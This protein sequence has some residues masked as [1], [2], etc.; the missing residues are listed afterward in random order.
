MDID[1][2]KNAFRKKQPEGPTSV[3]VPI[4]AVDA[5]LDQDKVD[6]KKSNQPEDIPVDWITPS[7]ATHHQV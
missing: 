2:M 7:P 6:D 4:P 1:E 5:T 3:N